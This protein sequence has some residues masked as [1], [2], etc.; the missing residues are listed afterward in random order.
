MSVG[1]GHPPPLQGCTISS[2]ISSLSLLMQPCSAA[3]GR[4]SAEHGTALATCLSDGSNSTLHRVCPLLLGNC[5]QAP[6]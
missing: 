1:F 5:C 2:W 6:T 3:R 4:L